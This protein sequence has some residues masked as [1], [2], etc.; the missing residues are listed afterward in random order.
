MVLHGLNMIGLGSYI[1]YLSQETGVIETSYSFLFSCRSFG[2]LAGAALI[3]I[4]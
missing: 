3:K 2:M 1:P 4:L